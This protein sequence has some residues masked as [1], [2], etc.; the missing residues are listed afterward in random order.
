MHVQNAAGLLEYVTASMGKKPS[1]LNS[2]DMCTV[3]DVTSVFQ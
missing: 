1:H 2:Y 3:W